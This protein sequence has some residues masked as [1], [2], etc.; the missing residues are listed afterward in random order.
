MFEFFRMDRRK[1]KLNINPQYWSEKLS[2]NSRFGDG[3]K[4]FSEQLFRDAV[5]QEFDAWVESEEPSD[6]IKAELWEDLTAE[7][8]FYSDGGHTLA[9]DAAME[10]RPRNSD[11]NFEMRDFYE[12]RL[13]DYTFHFI[14]C[15]YAIAWGIEKYDSL[16]SE[17]QN[18]T[19]A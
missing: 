9:I 13:E 4:E 11:I 17:G 10:F 3:F 7:V 12:H 15:C 14:W 1:G 18:G 2:A 6:E 19:A 16:K 5:K 8:L